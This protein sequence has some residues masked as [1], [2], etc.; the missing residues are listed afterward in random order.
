MAGGPVAG[1][2]EGGEVGGW[3]GVDVQGVDVV[4]AGVGVGALFVDYVG[5]VHCNGDFFGLVV[6]ELCDSDF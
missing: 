4:D 6:G 1:G 3:Q 5:L 2:E